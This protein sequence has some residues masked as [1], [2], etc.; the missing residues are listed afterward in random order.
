M[1]LSVMDLFIAE[2]ISN[3]NPKKMMGEWVNDLEHPR[4]TRD[5]FLMM[6]MVTWNPATRVTAE[7]SVANDEAEVLM[8]LLPM[9]CILDQRAIRFAR[10]FF[11]SDDEEKNAVESWSAR[12]HKIPPPIFRSFCTKPCK[13]KIDYMP[14][15][16]DFKALKNGCM[17]ELINLSPLDGMVLTLQQVDIEDAEGFGAVI[18]N[19]AG[20]WLRDICATQ[21]H[22]FLSNSRPFE[23]ITR[24]SGGVADLFVLPWDAYKNGDSVNRALRSSLSSLAGTVTYETLTNTSRITGYIAGKM[25]KVSAG[26]LS[27]AISHYDPL[28]SRPIET[29][30]RVGDASRHAL[31]SL[32]RG[33]QTA[34]YKIVVIPF[35]EYRR[36]GATGAVTSM[37][38]G[39]PVA[40]VA[41]V[42][43]ATEALS[44]TLLSA[45]NQILP[46]VRKEEEAIRRGLHFDG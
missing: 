14:Q 26:S 35:R 45:R 19:L 17:V 10:L 44:Y 28:P 15:K 9:R 38:K 37:L 18:S 46:E 39:I 32:A 3:E 43:G 8:R 31:E 5:G 1:D 30:K 25:A 42:S 23:P 29:P 34:N 13:L 21:M 11:G 40:V 22:K 33:V 7:N 16:L 6:K 4:D 20:G 2:T 12:L 24:I 41:P 36:K 27:P